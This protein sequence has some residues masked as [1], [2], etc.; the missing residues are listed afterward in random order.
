MKSSFKILNLFLLILVLSCQSND[1]KSLSNLDYVNPNI[2]GVGFLL[3]PVYP[4]VQQPNQMIRMR[5]VRRDYLDDQI[6]FFSLSVIAHREGELFG[7]L[8]G[9][10]DE[11]GNWNVKQMYDHDQEILKPHYYSTY[12]VEDEITTEFVPGKRSGYF[13]FTYPEGGTKKLKFHVNYDGSWKKGE[14][15][16]LIGIEEFRGMKAFVYGEF[17]TQ[18]NTDFDTETIIN[19]RRKTSREQANAWITFPANQGKIDFRYAISYISIEQAK[20]NLQNEVPD[21]NFDGLKQQ[22]KDIWEATLNQIKVEGG[23]EAQRRVFYTSLYRTYERMVSITENGQYYSN[24]DSTVHTTDRNFYTDDW[25][26]DSYLTHHP[27]RMI[28]NPD[29]EADML[30]SYVNMYVESGWLPQF[31]ILYTDKPAMHGFHSTIT[32]LDAYKK[33]IRNFDLEKAYKGMK[34]NALEATMI[35]WANKEKTE[36][37]DFYREKGYFPALQPGEEETVEKVH[38]FEKRQSVAITM[39]HSYDD[40]ALGQMAKELNKEDDY[41]FFNEQS[42]NYRNLYRP[43]FG[44]MMPKDSEGN[45]IDIDPKFDGGPGGRDYYDENNGYTYAW[46]TQHDIHGLIEL[47]GGRNGFITKLDNLFRE[48]LGRTKFQFYG[49]FPDSSGM[50][51]QF[52]MGNEPSFHIPYLYNYAGQ[53][54]KTQKRVRHLLDAW[55][56][57]SIFGIPGDEDGGAM[58]SWVVFSSMGFYPVTPG[59]PVY[60]IGSPV[61]EKVVIDLPNGK[62]FTILANNSSKKNKYIQSAKLN[63][64]E[65]NK[66]WFTHEDILNGSILAVEMGPYPNMDWGTAPEAAPPSR[67]Q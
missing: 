33:G 30:Q 60:T 34:K 13:H 51:G 22:A 39:A 64:E 44:L 7:V 27:L 19:K 49:K 2:G 26:W 23:T 17:N 50:T 21:W 8:P 54:W 62:A 11:E 3:H 5:P 16:S 18:I 41:A 67:V 25:V 45:W 52:S 14:G 37:D 58:T 9:L 24:F 38:W 40:W 31:P 6:S 32:L 57:D 1:K 36:L 15:N 66:T 61:F 47:M 12:F 48:D 28:L 53:P 55:F 35:P 65:L 43:E 29:M 56:Q 10:A 59:L 20:Q 63:G 42:L 46:Q 4:N